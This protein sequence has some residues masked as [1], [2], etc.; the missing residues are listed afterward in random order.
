MV[1]I[2]ARG[3][4]KRTAFTIYYSQTAQVDLA[5]NLIRKCTLE[6]LEMAGL[7][8]PAMPSVPPNLDKASPS[9]RSRQISTRSPEI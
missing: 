2:L 8:A 3:S 5:A 7:A 9:N 6:E 4:G 1:I